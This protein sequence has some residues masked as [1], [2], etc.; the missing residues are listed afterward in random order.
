MKVILLQEVEKLGKKYET[1]EVKDGYARNFL[2]PRKLAKLATKEAVKWA[3]IQKEILAKKSE[4]ELESVQEVA[5]KIDG[6]ELPIV[7]K[8]GEEGQLFEKITAQKISE[9]M[10]EVGF[11][12]KKNQ[13]ILGEPIEE[14]GEYPIKIKLAHNLEAEIRVIITEEKI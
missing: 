13:I 3:E 8:I 6:L 14:A 1:R 12:I 10:K 4:V 7:V 9:K 5:T 11:D 2:I